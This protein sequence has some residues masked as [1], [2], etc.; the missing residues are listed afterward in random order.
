MKFTPA[1]DDDLSQSQEVLVGNVYPAKGGRKPNY[2]LIVSV[3]GSS[4]H[5]LGLNAEGEIV[6]ATS[7]GLHA[8]E[9][10]PIV[11]HCTD[12]SIVNLNIDWRIHP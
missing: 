7:Y 11:G 4:A 2:W 12:L 5:A 1:P 9:D 10:R 6:S 3:T 8:F